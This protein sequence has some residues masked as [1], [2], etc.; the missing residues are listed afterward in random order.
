[1]DWLGNQTS[2]FIGFYLPE[3]WF[4]YF[5]LFVSILFHSDLE[6]H[7][8]FFFWIPESLRKVLKFFEIF[9]QPCGPFGKLNQS[10]HWVMFAGTAVWVLLFVCVGS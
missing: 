5:A 3:Q 7:S 9:S 1:M 4:G 2:R 6:L 10:V 8:V